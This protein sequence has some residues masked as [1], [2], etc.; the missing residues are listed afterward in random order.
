MASMD[1]KKVVGKIMLKVLS[2]LTP[3][4]VRELKRLGFKQEVERL[5]SDRENTLTRWRSVD[6]PPDQEAWDDAQTAMKGLRAA[7][8]E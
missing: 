4:D 2:A 7:L 6:Y 3:D 5:L 1:D 8:R